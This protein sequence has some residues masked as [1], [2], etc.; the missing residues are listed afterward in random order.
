MSFAALL[1]PLTAAVAFYGRHFIFLGLL[2]LLPIAI[3][4]AFVLQHPLATGTGGS[5]LQGVALLCRFALYLAIILL[6]IGGDPR[7]ALHLLF[8]SHAWNKAFR[9]VGAYLKRQWLLVT[10]QLLLL[11]IIFALLTA[12]VE[13]L[14]HP[15]TLRLLV[16][17]T[18]EAA[19]AYGNI[20]YF[21]IRNAVVMPLYI[22]YFILILRGERLPRRSQRNVA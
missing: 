14:T 2:S 21:T 17:L 10:G 16:M 3:H 8:D 6:L 18:D 20:I 9:Q 12:G 7:S 4:A 11:I 1:R 19:A 13:W 22:I 5:I 15:T